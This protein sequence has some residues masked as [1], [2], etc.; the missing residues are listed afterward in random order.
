MVSLTAELA[1]HC[2]KSAM[3]SHF[4]LQSPSRS[5]CVVEQ[6]DTSPPNVRT[7]IHVSVRCANPR[8]NTTRA[9]EA[10]DPPASHW[11]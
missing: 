8:Q 6:S 10:L 2:A 5:Q 4:D 11:S 7:H 9:I 1:M 3:T